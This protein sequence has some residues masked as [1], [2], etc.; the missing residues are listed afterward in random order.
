MKEQ[1]KG[2][3]K[4]YL[5]LLPQKENN[6]NIRLNR[7]LKFLKGC[8]DTDKVILD[9]YRLYNHGRFTFDYFYLKEKIITA[10]RIKNMN[11]E[12]YKNW[13]VLVD[14]NTRYYLYDIKILKI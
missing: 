14:M 10:K 12:K 3:N 13:I 7:F 6:Y 11:I 1:I 9:C 5:D 4:T 8:K 2:F